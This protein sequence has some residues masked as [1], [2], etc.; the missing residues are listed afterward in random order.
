MAEV[1]IARPGE[2]LSKFAKETANRAAG[3]LPHKHTSLFLYRDYLRVIERKYEGSQVK[4]L[5][6]AVRHNFITYKYLEDKERMQMVGEGTRFVGLLACAEELHDGGLK[7][8]YLKD[9][10]TRIDETHRQIDPK[11]YTV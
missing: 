6:N 10:F 3:A 4:Y 5:K 7:N 8:A 11:R 2:R 1:A 9:P